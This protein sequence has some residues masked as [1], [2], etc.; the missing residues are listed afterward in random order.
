MLHVTDCNN[1]AGFSGALILA[2]GIICDFYKMDRAKRFLSFR[3]SA[4]KCVFW[5]L[6]LLSREPETGIANYARC[7]YINL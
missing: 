2:A 1:R 7:E 6:R 3:G 4:A 5:R